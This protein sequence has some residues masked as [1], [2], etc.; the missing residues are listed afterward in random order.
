MSEISVRTLEVEDWQEYREV[1]LAALQDSPHAFLADYDEE[2]AQPEQFWRDRMARARRFL[3]VADGQGQGIVSLGAHNGDD[4]DA[5]GGI[6]EIFGL[7]VT[8]ATRNSGVAWQL[9]QAA[10]TEATKSGLSQLYY[11]VGTEN[12]RG[13][14]FATNFGF[15]PSSSRRPTRV[16][17]EEFG[18]QEIAMVMPLSSDPG[19]VPNPTR[20]RPTSTSGPNQ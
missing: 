1:R 4:G 12:G 10:A 8:P 13:I 18:E 9:V 5:E 19:S 14:A 17:N 15:R 11:W 20:G 2:A 3:A 6:G 7:W 16:T